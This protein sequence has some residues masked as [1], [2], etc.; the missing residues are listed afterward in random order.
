METI[1][2]QLLSCLY[3]YDSGMQGPVCIRKQSLYTIFWRLAL[4]HRAAGIPTS[5]AYVNI[6]CR[7]YTAF[8]RHREVCVKSVYRLLA[9]KE[10]TFMLKYYLNTPD[11]GL[12]PIFTFP[13]IISIQV[14]DIIFKTPYANILP[15]LIFDVFFFCTTL[16]FAG[17]FIFNKYWKYFKIM[18]KGY[19]FEI[20]G[21]LIYNIFRSKNCKK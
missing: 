14:L 9:S 7:R 19:I 17:V 11:L 6:P 15:N 4:I 13:F 12:T 3:L 5:G 2:F 10:L 20:N 16:H 8:W 1:I 21:L 18:L